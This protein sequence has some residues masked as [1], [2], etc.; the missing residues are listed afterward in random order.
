[1]KK[2]TSKKLS[3]RLAQYGALTAAIAG[4]SDATGQVQYTDIDP[5]ETIAGSEYGLDL[6]NDGTVDYRMIARSDVPAV[7]IYTDNSSSILGINAGGNYNYPLAMS[8]GDAI[9]AAGG[10]GAWI[11]APVYQTLNWG[12]CAYT[13]SQWCDGQVDK[14]LGLRINVGPDQHYGWIRLDL[15]A[16]GSSFTVKDYALNLTAGEGLDAGEGALGTDD[17]VFNGFVQ[18]VSDNQLNLRATTLMNSVAVYDITGKQVMT[19]DLAAAN[20]QVNLSGLTT[21]VYI[22]TV[23]IEGSEKSFKFVK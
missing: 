15:P 23:T 3:K 20:A 21:G 14:Y 5:D 17:Q 8:S 11:T 12:G 18:F 13:S 10:G 9:D 7:R 6:N 4:V 19:Q 2:I 1:M 16:D 22:A